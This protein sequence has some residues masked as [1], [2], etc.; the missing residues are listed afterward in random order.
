M[1]TGLRKWSKTA[2]ANG[3]ADSAVNWG[4]G[5]APSSINDSSRGEMAAAAKWRDDNSGSLVGTLSTATYSV[6]SNQT[7]DAYA[8]GDTIAFQLGSDMPATALLN[9]D[10]LGA[11]PLRPAPGVDFAGGEL[12]SG[13]VLHAAYFS[14]NSGEW[15][16][17]GGMYNA[18]LPIHNQTAESAQST[19][20]EIPVY[21]NADS[22]NRK[23]TVANLL[24]NV[25]NLTEDTAPDSAADFV[26]SYDN[27]ATAAKK[28]KLANLPSSLPRGGIDGCII[29]N[30]SGD[31]TNDIDIAAGVCRDS[32]N[33]VDI[34]VPAISGKKLD[35]NWAAGGSAGMRYSGAGISD[36]SYG[37]YAART[38]AS[39]TADIYSYPLTSGTDADTASFNATVL[40]ALQAETGGSSY[41]YLRRIG[42]ILREGGSL[43][44]FDQDGDDFMRRAVP[45]SSAGSNPGTSANLITLKV[46][47]GLKVMARLMFELRAPSSSEIYALVTSPDQTDVA[48]G[49]NGFTAHAGNSGTLGYNSVTEVVRRVNLAAQVRYRFSASSTNDVAVYATQAWRDNRGANVSA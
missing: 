3:N 8:A 13:Q 35:A 11:K 47:I 43:V 40:A 29:S 45:F 46:P 20:D 17:F 24:K 34:V 26:L 6:T 38:A 5:Q 12:K 48:P 2:A 33:T 41:A 19:S 22:A 30:N 49:N 14:S 31:A 21:S 36:T 44:L 25:N 7:F 1:A 39:A 27:S 16:L 42:A 32:T 18:N 4:E 23:V 15:L 9:V 28:V 10:G 37:V